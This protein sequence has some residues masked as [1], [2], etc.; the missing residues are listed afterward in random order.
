MA[1]KTVTYD[2]E[3]IKQNAKRLYNQAASIVFSSIIVGA[4]VGGILGAVGASAADPQQI[5]LFVVV[6]AVFGS[7]VDLSRGRERSLRLRL[8]AQVALC[9][10]QIEEN[11]RISTE[12]L[13]SREISNE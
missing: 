3:V 1:T 9:Q 7:L 4:V 5:T 12:K 6:G 13:T 2:A 10:V 8:E 11:T